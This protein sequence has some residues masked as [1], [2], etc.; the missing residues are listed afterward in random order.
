MRAPNLGRA[1]VATA[2]LAFAALGLACSDTTGPGD[3]PPVVARAAIEVLTLEVPSLFPGYDATCQMG[4]A[5]LLKAAGSNDP[6]GK[7]LT[8][9]WRDTIDGYLVPDFTPRPNPMKTTGLEVGS[10]L[11]TP[12]VH[13]ITLTVTASDGRKAHAGLR[14]MV[15][16]CDCGG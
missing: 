9:E 14:V 3:L 13:E 11:F 5:V 6:A 2:A 16:G 7:P 15:T 1:R 12:G 8:F 4:S 10:N